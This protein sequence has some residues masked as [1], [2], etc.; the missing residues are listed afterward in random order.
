MSEV[1]E[2]YGCV[3]EVVGGYD[4]VIGVVWCWVSAT[5]GP[6]MVVPSTPV[7]EGC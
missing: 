1:V 4:C 6:A 2:G 3:V 5:F 7:G